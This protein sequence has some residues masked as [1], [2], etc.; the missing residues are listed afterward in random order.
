MD[1]QLAQH[2]DQATVL[3][4]PAVPAGNVPAAVTPG[5]VTGPI[6]A[7]R[8]SPDDRK[9][10]SSTKVGRL[11]SNSSGLPSELLHSCQCL[12]YMTAI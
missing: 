8:E 10:L 12:R 4:S 6:S 9:L 5:S 7:S 2:G 1:V 3:E 11:A